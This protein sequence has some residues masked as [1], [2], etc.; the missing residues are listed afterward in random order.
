MW[1]NLMDALNAN[2]NLESA[3][4]RNDI[5]GVKKCLDNGA[6]IDHQTNEQSVLYL[7]A[8]NN[9]WEIAEYLMDSGANVNTG[10][11][12]DNR[13]VHKI[14]ENGTISL[15]EKAIA[16]GAIISCHDCDKE[17]PFLSAV[18]KNRHDMVDFM[19]D[20]FGVN[21]Q[22]TDKHGK[23]GLHY[24]AEKGY[25]EMF[26]KLWYQGVDIACLDKKDKS[27]IDYIKDLEWKE[28]LPELEQ[29]VREIQ[30]VKDIK[31][32]EKDKENKEEIVEVN[33]LKI[34]GVSSIKRKV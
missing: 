2:S 11:S 17:T 3:V 13:L 30:K 8:L 22:T 16:L 23:N 19:C 1:E 9:Y 5:E 4:L 26:M 31:Q 24:A 21:I 34:T 10:N 28:E 20:L 29:E 32:A 18:K 27:P 12:Y 25:K 14:V 33:T 15:L 6:N 7:A